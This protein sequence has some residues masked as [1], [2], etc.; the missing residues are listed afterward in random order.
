MGALFAGLSFLGL[1]WGERGER[2]RETEIKKDRTEDGERHRHTPH[3]TA[4][5]ERHRNR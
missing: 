3:T 5:A 1:N 4:A 2:E